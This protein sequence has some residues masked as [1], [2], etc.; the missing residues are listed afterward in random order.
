MLAFT[1][2]SA[3]AGAAYLILVQGEQPNVSSAVSD[4]R[5]VTTC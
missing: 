4:G 5:T 1:S 3:A 2:I